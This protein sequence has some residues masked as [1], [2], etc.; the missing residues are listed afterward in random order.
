MISGVKSGGIRSAAAGIPSVPPS[1]S[2]TPTRTPTGHT[3]T[4]IDIVHIRSR[5]PSLDGVHVSPGAIS[6]HYSVIEPT[7]S[8]SGSSSHPGEFQVIFPSEFSTESYDTDFGSRLGHHER[9]QQD[10]STSDSTNTRN[11]GRPPTRHLQETSPTESGDSADEFLA[12]PD[13]Y[14][15]MGSQS[16][17]AL[18]PYPHSSSSGSFAYP[19]FPNAHQATP[20]RPQPMAMPYPPHYGGFPGQPM[21]Y[22][23]DFHAPTHASSLY[24]SS[25]YAPTV[26][27]YGGG[28]PRPG[29]GYFPPQYSPHSG[30]QIPHPYADYHFPPPFVPLSAAGSSASS[31][32]SDTETEILPSRRMRKRAQR[33]TGKRVR[34]T[35]HDPAKP[36]RDCTSTELRPSKPTKVEQKLILHYTNAIGEK[37]DFP[38]SKCQ[39][40]KVRKHSKILLL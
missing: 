10:S 33:R 7:Q 30:Q 4:H 22:T 35:S 34:S 11:L 16:Q 3:H 37:F 15:H 24:T 2:R 19:P 31:S 23:P 36:L 12:R 40:W 28:L 9:A 29:A 6:P 21:P 8:Q 26:V 14:P 17:Y 5:S 1:S 39:S 13:P 38:F 18:G 25:P 27:N 32:G 20:I